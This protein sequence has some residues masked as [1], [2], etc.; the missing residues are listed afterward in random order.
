MIL[1]II[2]LILL[3][4]SLF[5]AQKSLLSISVLISAFAHAM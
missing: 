3:N 2:L 5:K 1:K 4:K